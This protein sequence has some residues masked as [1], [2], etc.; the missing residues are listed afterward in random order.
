[1]KKLL[2]AIVC[3]GFIVAC[4][5]PKGDKAAVT[6]AQDVAINTDGSQSFAVNTGTSQVT[7]VGYKPGD[8]HNGT[9]NLKSGSINMKDG[10]IE[11]GSFEMD[12]TTITAT[13]PDMDEEENG[14]LTGHLRSSDFFN[15]DT[16]TTASFDITKVIKL[17][18]SDLGTHTIYGNLTLN[19]NTN[20][21]SFPATVGL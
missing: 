3:L 14:K 4:K 11:S 17:T 18:G 21:V 8:D 10:N 2:F 15:V 7:W 5:G 16:N 20:N 19:G 1:M 6:D 12:L 13:D 9:I